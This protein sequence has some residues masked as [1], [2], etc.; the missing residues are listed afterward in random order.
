M[1]PVCDTSV[2]EGGGAGNARVCEPAAGGC[3]GA[4]AGIADGEGGDDG[5]PGGG[6]TVGC[7]RRGRRFAQR[8]FQILDVFLRDRAVGGVGRLVDVALVEPDRLDPI[9]HQAVALGDVV[10]KARILF[11]EVR[12]LELL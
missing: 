9:A 2:W 8:R 11:G 5:G 1:A 4:G 3:D 7:G 12:L 10:E 6:M